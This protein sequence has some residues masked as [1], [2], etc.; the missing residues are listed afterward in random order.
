[1]PKK[2][3]NVTKESTAKALATKSKSLK[4]VADIEDQ[5]TDIVIDYR[6]KKLMIYT[7]RATVMNR[8]DRMELA[9][10]K[11]DLLDGQVYSRQYEVP[12]KDLGTFL[13]TGIFKFD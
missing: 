11:Q 2:K 9:Y 4:Q 5:E 12:S 10:I 3:V 6:N 7:N 8:L 1:M 13:R